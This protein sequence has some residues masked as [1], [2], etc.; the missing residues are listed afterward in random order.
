MT[1]EK[2]TVFSK[3]LEKGIIEIQN[4][5]ATI[6]QFNYLKKILKKQK[7]IHYEISNFCQKN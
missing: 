4:E 3:W 6:K 5:N 7:Y 2:N 1:I